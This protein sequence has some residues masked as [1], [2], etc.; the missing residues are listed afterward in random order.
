MINCCC[1]THIQKWAVDL[2]SHLGGTEKN[3]VHTVH[4]R[5]GLRVSR[6]GRSGSGG[7]GRFKVC[8]SCY[9][10]YIMRGRQLMHLSTGQVVV[11]D[12]YKVDLFHNQLITAHPIF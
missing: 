8:L 1:S 11:C 9:I 6:D 3:D 10:Y 5:R 4:V 12:M 2:P 7:K